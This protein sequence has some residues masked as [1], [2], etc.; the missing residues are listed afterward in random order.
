MVRSCLVLVLCL[1]ICLPL[2]YG[3]SAKTSLNGVAPHDV[4]AISILTKVLDAAGGAAALSTIQDFTASG[5]ITYHWAGSDVV[6]TATFS[7]K[8]IDQFRMDATL[9]TGTRSWAA[10]HGR[11]IQK[12]EEGNVVPIFG[13]SMISPSA[14][15]LPNLIIAESIKSRSLTLEYQGLSQI[16]GRSVYDV[17]IRRAYPL[18]DGTVETTDISALD[19]FIDTN[20]FRI[21]MTRDQARPERNSEEGQTHEIRFSDFRVVNNVTVPFS[22]RETTAGQNTWQAQLNNFSFNSSLADSNFTF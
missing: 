14:L 6:G 15:I 4:Q 3:Q 1:E 8:S 17:R 10:N 5:Q 22:I 20:L 19:I 13:S 9:P 18:A 12:D 21:V 16:D 7:G 2:L 11:T